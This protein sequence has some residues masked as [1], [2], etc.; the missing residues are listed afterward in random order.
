[1]PA[2]IR[3]GFSEIRSA[4]VARFSAKDYARCGFFSIVAL[5]LPSQCCAAMIQAQLYSAKPV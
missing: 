3:N 1:M 2:R 5:P 4:S